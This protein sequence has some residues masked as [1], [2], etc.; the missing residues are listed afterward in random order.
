M[1]GGQ[2]AEEKNLV[3]TVKKRLTN[4][5]SSAKINQLP[6]ERHE[7]LGGQ[8]Q[9]KRILKNFKKVLDKFDNIC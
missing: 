6:D 1:S 9:I 8:R 7:P 4:S 3:K 5:M 2:R